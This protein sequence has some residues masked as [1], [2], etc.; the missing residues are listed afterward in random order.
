VTYDSSEVEPSA[1]GAY[2]VVATVTDSNYVGS[3]SDTFV[4]YATHDIT[5]VP[6][7]NLVSFNL[8]PYPGTDPADVLASID[9]DFDLVYGWDASGAHSGSG[10]WMLFDDEPGTTDTLTIIDEGMGLWIHLTATENQVLRVEGFMPTDTDIE[11]QIAASGWNLVGFPSSTNE[12]SSTAFTGVTGLSRVY[13]YD[14]GDGTSPWKLYD[15]TAPVYVSDL[16]SIEY[17]LGYWIYVTADT[18]WNVEY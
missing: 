5:L 12:S 9:G 15:P 10:N 14:A 13:G 18:T 16:T 2:A 1:T 3:A 4:I 8:E 17:G 11:L 7:W 6:G